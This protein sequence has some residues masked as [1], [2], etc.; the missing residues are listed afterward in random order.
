MDRLLFGVRDRTT[1]RALGESIAKDILVS[2]LDIECQPDLEIVDI[3]TKEQKKKE[4]KKCQ[5]LSIF[6]QTSQV[7]SRNIYAFSSLPHSERQTRN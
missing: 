4:K 7:S 1:A 2:V 6:R 5:F 3:I